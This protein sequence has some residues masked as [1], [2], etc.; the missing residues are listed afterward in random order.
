MMCLIALL[1][2]QGMLFHFKYSFVDGTDG[3]PRDAKVTNVAKAAG[4]YTT[5]YNAEKI[6]ELYDFPEKEGRLDSEVILFGKI[7]GVSY[8]FD[9][10]PAI[11]T[12]WADLDS[13]TIES[14]EKELKALEM[15]ENPLVIVHEDFAG[16]VLADKKYQI[17]L[18][19]INVKDY[20]IIF[21]S[22]FYTV[23][24]NS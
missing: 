4:M 20:N 11:S 23:Y 9:M 3:T 7:P 14:F 19:Y 17:L 6:S 21:E 16:E 10:Q 2:L 24:G 18:D 5:G 22:D 15:S 12:T 13:N 1:M 8:L